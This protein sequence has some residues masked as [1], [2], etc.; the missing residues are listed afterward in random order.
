MEEK[1]KYPRLK[2]CLSITLS[3]SQWDIATETTNISA[4]GAYC[5]IDK[6]MKLM[7]KLSITLF[8]PL[9]NKRKKELRKVTCNGV[10]VR[11]ERTKYNGKYPYYV[12]IYFN[13]IRKTDR[14][15]LLSYIN[16]FLKTADSP[17]LPQN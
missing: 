16:S 14:K 4:S 6:P 15:L 1:R 17:R 12:G 10:V 7:T 13:E 8:V 2:D 9:E 11:N 5:A 3:E